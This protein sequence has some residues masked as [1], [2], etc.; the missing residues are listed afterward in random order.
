MPDD[1]RPQ[2]RD[3]DEERRRWPDERLDDLA[4]RIDDVENHTEAL[5][6]LV[7]R[8]KGIR[9]LLERLE[10]Q[11]DQNAKSHDKRFG[12]L[13]ADIQRI[14]KAL[15]SERPDGT[16]TPKKTGTDWKVALA[17]GVGTVVPIIATIIATNGGT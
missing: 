2:R 1:E 17:A 9:D 14:D 4:E 3:S 16:V 10:R 12:Q 7:E 11:L 5:V 13:R 15:L 6:T 8:V